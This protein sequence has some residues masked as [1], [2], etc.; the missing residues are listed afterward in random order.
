M[1]RSYSVI[2]GEAV[3]TLA[4]VHHR[5]RFQAYKKRSVKEIV[6]ESYEVLELRSLVT[7]LA[8]AYY[9]QELFIDILSNSL[10]C[11]RNVVRVPEDSSFHA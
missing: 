9:L 11:N 7:W 4:P 5:Y 1:N 10:F 2:L 3:K 8:P 6:L